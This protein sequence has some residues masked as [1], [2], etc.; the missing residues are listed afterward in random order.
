MASFTPHRCAEH[1]SNRFRHPIRALVVGKCEYRRTVRPRRHGVNGRFVNAALDR[2]REKADLP[3]YPRV[4]RELEIE[5]LK[6]A[7][8]SPR[9][10]AAA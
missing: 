4:A 7:I 3:Q 8:F 6:N 10:G 2:L 1:R 9:K 5:Q